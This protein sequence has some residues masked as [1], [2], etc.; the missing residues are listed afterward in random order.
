MWRLVSS[1]Q[2]M[3]VQTSQTHIQANY[4]PA[5]PHKT[6]ILMDASL[7]SLQKTPNIECV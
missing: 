7:H 5:K 6:Q 1:G 2:V 4:Q 3:A